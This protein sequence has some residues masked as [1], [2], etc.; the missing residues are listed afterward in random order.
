MLKLQSKIDKLLKI[1]ADRL[2][3]KEKEIKEVIEKINEY[4]KRFTDDKNQYV[5]LY[6]VISNINSHSAEESDSNSQSRSSLDSLKQHNVTFTEYRNNKFLEERL[7][8]YEKI[9]EVTN[10]ALNLSTNIKLEIEDQGGLMN[11]VEEDVNLGKQNVMKGGEEIR[12]V[13]E[14]TAKQQ[15]RIVFLFIALLALVGLIIVLLRHYFI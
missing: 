7:K 1:L 14:I 3:R 5:D 2:P 8:E 10:A 9:K 4:E 6:I 13:E 12:K 15:K 11:S